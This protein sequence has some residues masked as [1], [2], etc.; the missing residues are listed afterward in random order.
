MNITIRQ[1]E[2]ALFPEGYHQ[3]TTAKG[4]YRIEAQILYQD[5]LRQ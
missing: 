2:A 1:E 3:A 4:V 5:I